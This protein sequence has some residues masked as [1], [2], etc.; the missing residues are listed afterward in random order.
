VTG[1]GYPGTAMEPVAVLPLPTEVDPGS[2]CA[3][4]AGE[5]PI[6]RALR[7]V[8]PAI[9][10]RCVVAVA[11]PLHDVVAGLV[12]PLGVDVLVVDPALDWRDTVLASLEHLG[13]QPLS[14]VLVHD[15]RHPLTPV[16]VAD[17]VVAALARGHETVVPVLAMTD[18][19]KELDA[20][21]AVVA[22]VDRTTLRTVQYPR[23]FTAGRLAD[24]LSRGADPV[25][26]ALAG[27]VALHTVDGHVDAGR[28][29]PPAD[30]AL[31][32]AILATRL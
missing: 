22:T 5:S 16:E 28:F 1:V 17:R 19:A 27:G 10:T 4:I 11:A 31:L 20:D 30:A 12:G 21:R 9:A 6:L 14:P 3:P 23:G 18:S 15:W 7:A 25:A 8:F 2:G 32:E 26:T 13:V 29:T 24:L